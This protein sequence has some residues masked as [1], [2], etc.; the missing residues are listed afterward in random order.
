MTYAA[1]IAALV[2]EWAPEHRAD[3]DKIVALHQD[4][5]GHKPAEAALRAWIELRPAAGPVVINRHHLSEPWPKQV[6]YVGRPGPLSNPFPRAIGIT[7]FRSTAAAR[8]WSPGQVDS[9]VG[10]IVARDPD[11][12]LAAY[13]T[14]LWLQ[15]QRGGEVREALAEIPASAALACSCATSPDEAKSRPC[16]AFIT[17]KAWRWLKEAR[18]A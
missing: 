2:S 11:A 18:A 6:V 10:R 16:H 8:G 4:L 1:D 14:D 12:V 5:G 9:I 3:F 7:E 15:L 17:V 13:R